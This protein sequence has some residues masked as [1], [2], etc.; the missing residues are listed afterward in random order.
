MSGK[1]YNHIEEKIKEAASNYDTSFSEPAWEKMSA[2]L[3]KEGNRRR[4]VAWWLFSLVLLCAV[5]GYLWM[6]TG[7][8]SKH[9]TTVGQTSS[10]KYKAAILPDEVKQ[11][12]TASD[13]VS[14]ILEKDKADPKNKVAPANENKSTSSSIQPVKNKSAAQAFSNKNENASGRHV[15]TF[16]RKGKVKTSVTNANPETLPEI[17]ETNE[18]QK[19]EAVPLANDAAKKEVNAEPVPEANLQAATA[20]TENVNKVSPDK[21]I[22]IA[23][24]DTSKKQ[25]AIQKNNRHISH[26]YFLAIAGVEAASV[27]F[28]SFAESKFRPVYGVGVGY[29]FSKKFSVQTGFYAG[30]KKYTAGPKDY[31]FKENSYLNGVKLKNVGAVCTVYEIPLVFRYSFLQKKSVQYF[32]T[33]GL[34]S[35]IMKKEAYRYDYWRYNTLYS[36]NYAYRGNSHLLSSFTFSAGIEKEISKRLSLIVSPSFSI[37]FSGVGDGKIKLFSAGMQAGLKFQPSAKK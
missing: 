21:P 9:P 12:N 13:Y 33:T 20:T 5:G 23:K 4:P 31:T 22:D 2:L 30:Q 6:Y 16:H 37:P 34:S 7:K 26:F 11:K 36:S 18:L 27:K 19:N 17:N 25:T 15:L 10:E 3:D 24:T 28:L 32:A 29:Q 1:P 8:N 35:Y 14:T